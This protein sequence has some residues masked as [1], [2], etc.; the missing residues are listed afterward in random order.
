M[1][2]LG[3]SP[4]VWIA[5]FL[6]AHGAARSTGLF[7]TIVISVRLA[8][9]VLKSHVRF[10]RRNLSGWLPKPPGTVGFL[11][12]LQWREMLTTL[13]PYVAAVLAV[14]T[15]TYRI[16]GGQQGKPVDPSALQIMS[17]ISAVAMST[18]AQVLFSLD[19]TGAQ[20]YRLM[21]IRGWRILLA[22]DLAF[23]C[24]LMLLVAPL[25]L[26]SGLFAGMAALVVGHHG[27]VYRNAPQARWRFTSGALLPDGVIQTVVLFGVG[28]N[29]RSAGLKLAL[30]CLIC[31]LASVFLYGWLWD[32]RKAVIAAH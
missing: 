10:P 19:G 13:D 2:S 3:F 12:M 21:P 17:L 14:L 24:L 15:V 20:R 5:L 11:M 30:P 28:I 1:V 4:I 9:F 27:S 6:L 26:V 32:R 25:D 22:K 29:I 16:S 23:L 31:W 7:L 8:A 18:T